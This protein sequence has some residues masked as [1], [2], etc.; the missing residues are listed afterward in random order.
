MSGEGILLGARWP[1]NDQRRLLMYPMAHL[2]GHA[3]AQDLV[4]DDDL[5]G[6]ID[7]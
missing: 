4:E 5:E 7:G 6:G 3:P 2:A 1:R